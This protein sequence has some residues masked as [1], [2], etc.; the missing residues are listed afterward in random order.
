MAHLTWV[1]APRAASPARRSGSDGEKKMLALWLIIQITITP[2]SIPMLPFR[3]ILMGLLWFVACMRVVKWLMPISSSDD[4]LRPWLTPTLGRPC[5]RDEDRRSSISLSICNGSKHG[6]YPPSL[7][8]VS[9]VSKPK[10]DVLRYQR[11]S[12]TF[13]HTNWQLL[14]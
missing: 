12:I 1:W 2:T 4:F 3:D 13:T 5:R 14:Q 6:E 8:I 7:A 10:I 11:N 9:G